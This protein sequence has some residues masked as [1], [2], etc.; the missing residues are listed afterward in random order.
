MINEHVEELLLKNRKTYHSLYFALCNITNPEIPEKYL[1][2]LLHPDEICCSKYISSPQAHLNFYLSHISAKRA[3]MQWKPQEPANQINLLHGS[4]SQ[5]YMSCH[6]IQNLSISITHC[7]NIGVSVSFSEEYL[8]GIDL[9]KQEERINRVVSKL[10]TN[11]ERQIQN[12]LST[13]CTI[14]STVL[15]TAKEALSKALKIGFFADMKIYEINNAVYNSGYIVSSFRFFPQFKA[16]SV[17][18]KD[19]VFTVVLP[20]E[21]EPFDF[22]KT[23][24]NLFAKLL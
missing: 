21:L 16:Y 13:N 4:F 17:P 7:H 11:Q 9:E 22:H 18:V 6:S 2:D 5:P 20:Y 15:W 1:L 23:I 3:F 12:D 8:I 19:F 24:T 10:L 14:A